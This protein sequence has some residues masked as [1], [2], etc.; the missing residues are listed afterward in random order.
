VQLPTLDAERR[1]PPL[2]IPALS[3]RQR[4]LGTAR[5]PWLAA[6]GTDGL[7]AMLPAP[8]RSAPRTSPLP[9]REWDEWKNWRGGRD[10]E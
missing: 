1:T 2:E 8:L 7:P 6:S 3:D 10:E 9:W 4:I 5:M